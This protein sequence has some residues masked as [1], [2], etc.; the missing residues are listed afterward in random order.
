M[1]FA[2]LHVEMPGK[3]VHSSKSLGKKGPPPKLTGKKVHPL[4]H[5]EK[6]STPAFRYPLHNKPS[7]NTP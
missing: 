6:R 7:R 5:L 3:K 2:V 4:N 1:H